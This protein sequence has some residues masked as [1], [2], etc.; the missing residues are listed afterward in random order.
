[1]K[2]CILL[3]GGMSKRMGKDKGSMKIN[4]KPMI[5]HVLNSLNNQID[6]A[7]IVLNDEKRIKKYKKIIRQ[8][9]Y[10]YKIY[11]TTD[12]IKDLGP[13]CGIMTGLKHIHSDYALVLPCDSPY[14]E[15]N[16]VFY[17]FDTLESLIEDGEINALVPYHRS[18]KDVNIIK[19]AEP[20]HSIYN[21]KYIPIME[22]YISQGILR[23]RTIMKNH[24][25][26]YIPID[27]HLIHEKNFKNFNRPT[28]I[29]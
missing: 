23:V 7:V 24:N 29:E 10:N 19:R 17:M 26:F 11:F 3:C 18:P 14:V 1:M 4:D 15:G 8:K 21:R 5:I 27:N 12:E 13:M 16:F 20:L 25:C 22:E 28:D 9:D 2:S 6:E